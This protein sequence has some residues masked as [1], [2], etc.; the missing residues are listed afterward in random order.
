MTTN[1]YLHPE[2]TSGK[3]TVAGK[4]WLVCDGKELKGN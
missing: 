1:G 3:K 2:T 4:S